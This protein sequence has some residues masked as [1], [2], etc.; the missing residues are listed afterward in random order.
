[1]DDLLKRLRKI[2]TGDGTGDHVTHWYRNPDGVEA[3][4]EIV[5]LKWRAKIDANIIARLRL[6]A[7]ERE[8]VNGAVWDYGQYADEMGLSVAEVTERQ[9]TLRK[10]L[11]RLK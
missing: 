7:E 3:A 2:E 5:K 6:T 1:M 4:E 9:N 10:L 11:E 8:A